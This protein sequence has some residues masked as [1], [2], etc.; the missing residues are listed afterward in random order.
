MSSLLDTLDDV[1]S[2]L[3]LML[4]G[5]AAIALL[6]GGVGIMNIMLVSVA[7]RTREIGIRK[8]IGARRAH[9]LLQFL[10]EAVSYTHLTLPTKAEV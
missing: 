3:S 2:T 5:I 7:E 8:A 9:I 10:I 6:V 4:G 1:M